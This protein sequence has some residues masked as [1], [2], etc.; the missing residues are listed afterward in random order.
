MI[1]LTSYISE[2][3]KLDWR[4]C[5]MLTM[6]SPVAKLVRVWSASRIKEDFLADDGREDYCHCT[7]LY[8]FDQD[9]DIVDVE[10]CLKKHDNINISLG[11]VKRF[12]ASDHRPGSDVLVIEVIPDKALVDLHNEL[13][14]KFQVQTTFP[15]YNPHV[16]IAYIKPGS[17]TELDGDIA[18]EGFDVECNKMTYSTG[19]SENRSRKQL[20][21]EEFQKSKNSR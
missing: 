5:L 9:V 7:I 17:L 13:K 4:G 11:K 19:S 14:S 20:T 8:G 6:P 10:A 21:F 15:N 1:E 2:S 3:K 16:T 12:P 18:F